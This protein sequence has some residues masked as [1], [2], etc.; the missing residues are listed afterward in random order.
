[1]SDLQPRFQQMSGEIETKKETV[2]ELQA[3]R[4]SNMTQYKLTESKLS[5]L[6]N[7]LDQSQVAY[8]DAMAPDND[9]VSS[10][11]QQARKFKKVQAK[12]LVK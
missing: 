12:K 9:K 10:I 5:E 4:S 8:D 1:M 3:Q 6:K 7:N 2:S 11:S